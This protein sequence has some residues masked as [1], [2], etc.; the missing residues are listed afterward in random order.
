MIRP[1]TL[2]TLLLLHLR[3]H[4][5]ANPAFLSS[6]LNQNF[7]SSTATRFATFIHSFHH[8]SLPVSLLCHR[9]D[10]HSL[11]IRLCN[12]HAEWHCPSRARWALRT[13]PKLILLPRLCYQ[14]PIWPRCVHIRVLSSDAHTFHTVVSEFRICIPNHCYL[15]ACRCSRFPAANAWMQYPIYFQILC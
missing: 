15:L 10:H 13:L 5:F 12:V 3:P 8:Y 2:L 6:Y 4:P 9:F 11:V 7:L 1:C 14:M